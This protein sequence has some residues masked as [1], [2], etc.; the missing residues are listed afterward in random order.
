MHS[1]QSIPER[2]IIVALSCATLLAAAEPT[3]FKG[4]D[5]GTFTSSPTNNPQVVLTED[6]AAGEATNLGRYKLSAHELIN[7]ATLDVAEGAFTIT[8][9]NGDTLTG[10]YS[11][12]ASIETPTILRYEVSG[13]I[14]S[15][16]GRFSEVTG[17]VAFFGYADLVSERLSETLLGVRANDVEESR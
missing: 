15:G 10:R 16:T 1:F 11:G 6:S 3:A 9:A 17:T 8:A 4:R 7:L 13:P 14:T 2:S 12:K 5:M